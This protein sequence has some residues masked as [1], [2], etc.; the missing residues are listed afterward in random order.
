M[1][2]NLTRIKITSPTLSLYFNSYPI[3]THLLLVRVQTK[4]QEAFADMIDHF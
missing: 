4:P 1:F 3:N 2:H